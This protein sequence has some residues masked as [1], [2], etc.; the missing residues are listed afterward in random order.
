MLSDIR[1]VQK[2]NC[3][4]IGTQI[5]LKTNLFKVLLPKRL[6]IFQYE[7]DIQLDNLTTNLKR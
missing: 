4:K 6:Q 3:G 1:T 2:P 5:H 7:V